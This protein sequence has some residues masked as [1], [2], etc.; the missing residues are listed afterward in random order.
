VD[1]GNSPHE[2]AWFIAVLLLL[3]VFWATFPHAS[4]HPDCGLRN[5]LHSWLRH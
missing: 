1:P 5:A 2:G 3:I 4:D